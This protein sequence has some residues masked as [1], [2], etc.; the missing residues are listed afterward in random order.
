MNNIWW[1]AFFSGA[2]IGSILTVLAIL[3]ATGGN[4]CT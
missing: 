2:V 3:F 1:G 4:G